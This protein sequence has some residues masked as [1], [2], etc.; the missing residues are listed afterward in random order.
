MTRQ[1]FQISPQSKAPNSAAP[2]LLAWLLSFVL[3]SIPFAPLSTK[4]TPSATPLSPAA[5]F[6][7][8]DVS[9]ATRFFSIVEKQRGQND[10]HG[11]LPPN[12]LRLSLARILGYLPAFSYTQPAYPIAVWKGISKRGPPF[13]L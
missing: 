7:D 1:Q 2:F 4:T 10:K 5:A 3:L 12:R 11:F 6:Y 8:V 13:F 9:L